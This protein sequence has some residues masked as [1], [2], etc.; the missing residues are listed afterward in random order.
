[1]KNLYL[2]GA[3]D[4]L[5]EVESDFGL[6]DEFYNNFVIKFFSTEL[7]A[8]YRY[9]GDWHI[10]IFGDIPKGWIVRKISGTSDFI[11]IQTPEDEATHVKLVS[12]ENEE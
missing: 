1:M 4:D 11:H 8:E 5:Y 9:D 3:S 6:S 12:K 10:G 2:Y 7:L